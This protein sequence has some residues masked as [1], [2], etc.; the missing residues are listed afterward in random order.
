MIV[1]K[2]TEHSSSCHSLHCLQHAFFFSPKDRAA[3]THVQ[4]RGVKHQ[5]TKETAKGRTVDSDSP[6]LKH[7]FPDLWS[8]TDPGSK[9]GA[10]RFFFCSIWTLPLLPISGRGILYNWQGEKNVFRSKSRLIHNNCET[11]GK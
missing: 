2:Y 4:V 8:N 5:E 7:R 11:K 1:L 9:E 6:E 10:L 3:F